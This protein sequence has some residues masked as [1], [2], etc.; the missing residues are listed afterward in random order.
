MNVP[1]GCSVVGVR[2]TAARPER[3]ELDTAQRWLWHGFERL[4]SQ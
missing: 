3:Q 4:V 1:P 2:E